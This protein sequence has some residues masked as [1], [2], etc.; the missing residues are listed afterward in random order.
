MMTHSG[1]HTSPSSLMKFGADKGEHPFT[2][3]HLYYMCVCYIKAINISRKQWLNT[4][5]V[6][7]SSVLPDQNLIGHQAYKMC[8]FVVTILDS[9]GT[10]RLEIIF[11][12]SVYFIIEA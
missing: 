8:L 3:I 6:D 10:A 1:S 12:S 5:I 4:K 2:S 11:H 9:M 7:K